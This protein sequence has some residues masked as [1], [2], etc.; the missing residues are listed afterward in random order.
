M[1]IRGLPVACDAM[2]NTN[3]MPFIACIAVTT[4]KHESEREE[5]VAW[6]KKA[7]TL[8]GVTST[9]HLNPNANK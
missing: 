5:Q 2:Q 9:L 7:L 1:L 8:S 4:T 6:V 3:T